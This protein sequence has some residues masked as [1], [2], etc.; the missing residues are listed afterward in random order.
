MDNE[1]RRKIELMNSILLSM[2]GTPIIYYG[3]EIG[4]GDNIYLGDRNGVRTPMQWTP[5]RNGGCAPIRT[6]LPALHHG[7]GLWLL[8]R[9][10]RG[11]DTP[12]RSSLLNWMKR[13]IGVRKSSNLKRVRPRHADVYL[14]QKPRCILLCTP[15]RRRSHLVRRQPVV[16]PRRSNSISAPGRAAYC[17]KCFRSVCISRI[18]ELPY[19][20]TLAPYGF[21]FG[22]VSPPM[23]SSSLSP[24]CR[25]NSRPWCSAPN[26][27]R[28]YPAGRGAPS[29]ATYQAG[30]PADRR[31]Y[32]DK[33]ARRMSAAVTATIPVDHGADRASS[34]P[35]PTSPPHTASAAISCR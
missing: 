5:D 13:L 34:S 23:P 4:M 26:G 15:A 18:G 3:D 31:W 10:R 21:F 22:S 7:P 29:R 27:T 8:G 25:A 19:L 14:P 35:S 1:D 17:T 28:R 11:T 16:R 30:L 2:P 20:V 6:A 33:G 32:A 9:Q 12:S 24:H